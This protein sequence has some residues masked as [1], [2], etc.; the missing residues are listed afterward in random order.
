MTSGVFRSIETD[1]IVVNRDERQRRELTDIPDL[2][3]SIRQNGLIEPILVTRDGHQL[4]AGE[5]RLA[6]V[7]S[8]GWTHVSAQ[9][10]DE[11]APEKLRVLELEENI[12]RVDLPWQDRVKA[13]SEYHAAQISLDPDWTV[14][15]SAEQ[16]GVKVNDVFEKISLAKEIKANPAVAEMPRYSIARNFVK[17]QNERKSDEQLKALETS[18]GEIVPEAQVINA[19]FLD[20]APGYTGPA[21]NLIHCDFPYGINMEK[22][23]QAAGARAGKGD[24][25]DSEELYWRLVRCLHDNLTR[26]AHLQ[27][28]MVFWYSMKFYEPTKTLL[29]QMGWTVD[30]FPLIWHKSDS[31]GIIPDP[32]RGPRRVYETAFLCSLGDRKIVRAVDNAVSLPRGTTTHM[33]EKPE[34]VLKHFF[35]MLVDS[36]TSILDP[37]AGSGSALR[38]ADAL[39]A[40]RVVGVE[41]NREFADKANTL[42]EA[43][44]K[45]K[46]AAVN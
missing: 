25:D 20:W 42:L 19:S 37:T 6:A 5:R 30:D 40:P 7:K 2:A 43:S 36:S 10:Q 4:V 46:A 31:A 15:R 29:R 8:L 26:V 3:N 12:R 23:D 27:C 21:F 38:A 17:R 33:S 14:E 39:G 45:A 41:I 13:V 34:A 32:Q 1:S 18:L 35:R 44:Q 11:I 22:S 16:L 9:Y 28:H 24:Y